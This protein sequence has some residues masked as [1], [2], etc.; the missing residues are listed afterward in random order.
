MNFLTILKLVLQLLPLIIQAV[1]TI[2]QQTNKSGLGADKLELVK[3]ILTDT[4]TITEDVNK[5]DYANAIEKTITLV[6][7]FFNKT[8]W[9]K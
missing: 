6:V 7:K 1:N 4:V 3:G 5:A 2:E 8:G 9:N